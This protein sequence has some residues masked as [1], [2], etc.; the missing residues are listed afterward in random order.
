MIPMTVDEIEYQ[1]ASP[2]E[3]DSVSTTYMEGFGSLCGQLQ[4]S[5]LSDV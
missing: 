5:C 1:Q 4:I 3:S 2:L